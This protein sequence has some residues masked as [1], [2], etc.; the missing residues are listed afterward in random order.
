MVNEDNNM[1]PDLRN[2]V[3]ALE[4]KYLGFDPRMAAVEAWQRQADIFNARKDEQFE[5]LKGRFDSLDK[6]IDTVNVNLSADLAKVDGT[7]SWLAR[8]IIGTIITGS[9]LGAIGLLFKLTNP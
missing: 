8:I 9:M 5:N 4:H 1:E 3:V 2:R 7:L 6:K